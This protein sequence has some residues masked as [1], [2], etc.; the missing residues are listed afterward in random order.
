MKLW[1]SKKTASQGQSAGA[2]DSIVWEAN[3]LAKASLVPFIEHFPL[4]RPIVE[5]QLM[6]VWDSLVTIAMAGVAAKANELLSDPLSLKELKI[7]L[8]KTCYAGAI[9]F[10]DYY[11]YT[12][13]RTKQ[14]GAP[15]SGVSAMWV[16][17]NLRLHSKANAALKYNSSQLDFV[18][19]LAAFMNMSFG[20]TEAG[21]S[22]FLGAM[23][24]D[25]EKSMGID[26]GLGTKEVKKDPETKAVLLV[27]IFEQFA[28][29]IVEMI[30]EGRK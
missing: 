9:G 3:T 4:Y 28:R 2:F 10:D 24:L 29:K 17:D 21:L 14:T 16:A 5:S 22:C 1:P 26:F 15:W 13:L 25:F 23:A 7:A 11:E 30:V 18:N 20:G 12:M 27:E 19:S 6:E 8:D